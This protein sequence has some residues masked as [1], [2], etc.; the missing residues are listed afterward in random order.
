MS[1]TRRSKV[2]RVR[3]SL[4]N[5]LRG[6]I[7]LIDSYARVCFLSKCDNICSPEN[8]KRT[9]SCYCILNAIN[10]CI[11]VIVFFGQISSMIEI[12]VEMETD[13]L[14]AETASNMVNHLNICSFWV[15]TSW[16]NKF[17]Y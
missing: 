14:A 1:R 3:E 7:E 11:T 6:R 12:E 2:K 8:Y 17:L 13:V 15:I 9:S 16:Y 10:V 5:S 4:Q